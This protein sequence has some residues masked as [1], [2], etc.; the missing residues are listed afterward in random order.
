MEAAILSLRI[1]S[2]VRIRSTCA[3]FCRPRKM[4]MASHDMR[5]PNNAKEYACFA[6]HGVESDRITWK[7]TRMPDNCVSK[8]PSYEGSF[9]T[10]FPMHCSHWPLFSASLRPT[11]EPGS[12]GGISSGSLPSISLSSSGSRSEP[13]C[14]SGGETPSSDKSSIAMDPSFLYLFNV[15]QLSSL[16]RTKN[17][18]T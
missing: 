17:I 6:S 13:D 5:A 9:S 8:N 12:D 7:G 16:R 2:S 14:H 1:Q 10:D 15:I 4:S 18:N 11:Y 3:G